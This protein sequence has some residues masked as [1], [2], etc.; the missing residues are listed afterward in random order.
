MG[1]ALPRESPDL[2]D[3]EVAGIMAS[4]PLFGVGVPSIGER[5][6]DGHMSFRL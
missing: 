5:C 6:P 3:G 1:K 4:S 2:W